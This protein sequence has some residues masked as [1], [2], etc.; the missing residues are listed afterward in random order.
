MVYQQ[1]LNYRI[2]EEKQ[3]AKV[4]YRYWPDND[5]ISEKENF[6]LRI[7]CRV[8]IKFVCVCVCQT[9]NVN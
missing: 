4:I 7:R 1:G 6:G 8:K 9:R 3:K 2:Y 5:T